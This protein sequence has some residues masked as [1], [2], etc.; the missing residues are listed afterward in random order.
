MFSP[1]FYVVTSFYWEG[2]LF[3]LPANSWYCY[4]TISMNTM[5]Y[6]LFYACVCLCVSVKEIQLK[7]FFFQIQSLFFR[8]KLVCLKFTQIE[9]IIYG[10]LPFTLLVSQKRYVRIFKKYIWNC[11]TCLSVKPGCKRDVHQSILQTAFPREGGPRQCR[12]EKKKVTQR[13]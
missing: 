11:Y 10:S 1:F 12:P 5:Y 4:R 3:I 6:V 13:I 7:L 2:K 8:C 9:N